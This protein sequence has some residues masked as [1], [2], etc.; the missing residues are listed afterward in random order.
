[1]NSAVGHLVRRGMEATFSSSSAMNFE[2]FDNT[3]KPAKGGL[4]LPAWGAIILVSTFIA[5]SFFATMVC[6]SRNSWRGI[7]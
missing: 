4:V 6:D 1:M 7:N 3:D 5:Y 2:H